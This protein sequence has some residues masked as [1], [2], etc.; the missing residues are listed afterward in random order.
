M[1][2]CLLLQD[3]LFAALQPSEA[4]LVG[5]YHKL[6]ALQ[7]VGMVLAHAS[8]PAWVAQEGWQAPSAPTH[9]VLQKPLLFYVLASHCLL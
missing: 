2:R 3:T 1:K 9:G 4:C 5:S 8:V 6:Q 7:F